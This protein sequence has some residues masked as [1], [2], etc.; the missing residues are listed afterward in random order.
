VGLEVDFGRL[1]FEGPAGLAWKR[2]SPRAGRESCMP[3][4]RAN[5]RAALCWKSS[6]TS[7]ASLLPLSRSFTLPS[8]GKQVQSIILFGAISSTCG[9]VNPQMHRTENRRLSFLVFGPA[10]SGTTAFAR[11]LNEHERVYCGIEA[12]PLSDD[13]AKCEMPTALLAR[14]GP[15]R[16]YTRRDIDTLKGKINLRSDVICGDKN[17]FY[18]YKIA[19]ISKYADLRYFNIYRDPSNYVYSWDARSRRQEDGWPPGMQGIFGAIEQIYCLKKIASLN[20]P[21]TSVSYQTLFF[22]DESLIEKVCAQIGVTVDA[23]FGER[24][25]A[26]IFGKSKIKSKHSPFYDRFFS[27][28]RFGGISSFFESRPFARTQHDG[29]R[30]AVHDQF[31]RLPSPSTFA[32]FVNELGRHAIL[33]G[34]SWPDRCRSLM[35]N[36]EDEANRWLLDYADNVSA[37]LRPEVERLRMRKTWSFSRWLAQA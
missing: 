23:K 14:S 31:R 25:K 20:V 32:E 36:C 30:D 37:A 19:S 16:W 10:R 22:D 12:L 2:A 5:A 15:V 9:W 28:Y 6:H 35:D 33:F 26:N 29:L 7:P 18:Q 13:V 8:C 11:A 1:S 34:H 4:S 21:V 24:F 17:P 3:G 27:E